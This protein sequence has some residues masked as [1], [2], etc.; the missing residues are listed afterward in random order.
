MQY[1]ATLGETVFDI[2]LNLDESKAAVNKKE[3]SFK[4]VEHGE[5]QIL[6]RVGTK[7]HK[8]R[9]ISIDGGQI[10][11]TVDGKW[12]SA[13]LKNEQQLLLERLGFKT[14]AEKSIGSLQA[15]MPGKI[16][17]LLAA[18]GD[19][20]ELGDPVAILEAMK[21]ENELKAPCAGTIQSVA[22]TKGASVEKNQILIEIEPRG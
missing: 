13:T 12:I 11:C 20:V 19:E 22:V 2:A 17:D 5:S 21:M 4:V 7:L 15:P 1:E 18:E 9:N 14:A 3:L 8:I 6:F 16:L 10:E